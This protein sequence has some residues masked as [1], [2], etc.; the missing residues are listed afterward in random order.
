[1]R[2]LESHLRRLRKSKEMT[3]VDLHAA[4]VEKG[5]KVTIP[6]L[7][8]VE[9]GKVWPTK[10]VVDM[11]VEFFSGEIK[12]VEILYPFRSFGEKCEN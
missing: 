10:I 12:E 6:T 11:L 9:R 8:N 2:L 3:M 1:M 7:S 4:L 5:H